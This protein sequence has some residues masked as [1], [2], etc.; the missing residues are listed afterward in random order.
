ME[1]ERRYTIA[2]LADASAAALDALGIAARNGQV[3]DR[4]DART[5]RYYSSLGLVD[6]PA[7]M[8]GRTAWYGDRH[9]L[10]VL[11]VKAL[12]ARGASLAEV[13]RALVGASEAELRRAVGPGLPGALAATAQPG[14]HDARRLRDQAFWRTPPSHPRA[15]PAAAAL[16]LDLGAAVPAAGS[17]ASPELATPE[18]ASPRSAPPQATPPEPSSAGHPRAADLATRPRPLLAISLA[19]GTTLLIEH[20]GSGG[21][22]TLDSLDTQAL[23]AAAAPL[24]AYLTSAGL[25]PGSPNHEGT[26]P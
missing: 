3:R 6:R 24:L 13:Q 19:E 4:P 23:R 1:I 15:E 9:L 7:D 17:E 18:P 11:A 21:T 12:Q 22:D 25:V 2:E 26:T 8:T 5:V 16:G 10:Q 20:A 14:G